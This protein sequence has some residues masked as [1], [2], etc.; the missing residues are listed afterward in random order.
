VEE[1]VGQERLAAVVDRKRVYF[2]R[3][4]GVSQR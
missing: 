2:R 3:W 4:L 1:D